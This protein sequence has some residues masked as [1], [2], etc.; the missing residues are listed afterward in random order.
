VQRGAS[1]RAFVGTGYGKLALGVLALATLSLSFYY[2]GPYFAIPTL[3]LFGLGVPIYLGWKIPRQ[4]AVMGIV[5]ILAT[6]PLIN[7]G[8]TG[9]AMTP[10]PA[11]NSASDAGNTSTGNPVLANALVSPY[12]AA[13]G[14]AFVFSVDLYTNRLAANTS[15]YSLELFVSTCPGATGNSSPF[16]GTGYPFYPVNQSVVNVTGSPAHR[17]FNVVL[18]GPN[19]WWWQMGLLAKTVKFVPAK[20]ATE[21]T[22]QWIFLAVPNAYGAVQGPVT[23]TWT[24]TY[25]LLLP[26]TILDVLF[27][28]G[29]VF[30]AALLVYMFLKSREAR[31]KAQRAG[32]GSGTIPPT[33]GSPASANPPMASL[34]PGSATPSAAG[35]SKTENACPKCGAVVYPKE[36]NCW[37]CGAPLTA[38]TNAPLSS[39]P[40]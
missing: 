34:P 19:I 20:N 29:L 6:G 13:G 32:A 25:K 35:G 23:G 5:V 27:Y 17:S 2:L 38:P 4:L 39:G 16:C 7:W 12:D 8:L 30:Y 21:T 40:A 10:S 18:P 24:S 14:T 31:R 22:Y 28:P 26:Q 9:Q 37:K 33:S 1:V 15:P 3:L 11:A 36:A